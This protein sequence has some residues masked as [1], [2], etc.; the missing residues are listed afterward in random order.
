[1]KERQSINAVKLFLTK[2]L[3]QVLRLFFWAAAIALGAL[4]AW[5]YRHEVGGDG[6][7]YIDMGDAYLR[8]DWKMAINALWSPLYAW[9]LALGL[10]LIKPSTYWEYTVVHSINFFIFVIALLCFELFLRQLIRYYQERSVGEYLTIPVPVWMVM[11][12]TL[13][14][15]SSLD[16]IGLAWVAPDM[17][18][19]GLLYLSFWMLLR[20]R[21]GA[22]SYLNFALLGVFLGMG[23]L[24]KTIMLPLAFVFLIVATF[25]VSNLRRA[26]PR[27]LMSVV[28]LLLIVSPFVLALSRA[29][30]RITIGDS[31]KLNYVWHVNGIPDRHWQGQPFG[32]GVPL[33]PTRKL[34]EQ[35]AVFEF[36]SPIGGTYPM[37]YDPSYWYEGVTPRFHLK[38]Q[39][40]TLLSNAE[41]I[42]GMFLGLGGSLVVGFILL[43]SISRTSLIKEAV[44]YWFLLVPAVT[45]FVLYLLV[46]VE[47][48]YVAPFIVMICMIT[49]A[50]VRLPPARD[51][52]RLLAGLAVA[53]LV[54]LFNPIGPLASRRYYSSAIPL[55][56]GHEDKSNKYWRVAEALKALGIEPGDKVASTSYANYNN[57]TW[58]R[59]ARVHIIAE[60]YYRPG[61]TG[62]SDAKL[63]AE[64]NNFWAADAPVQEQVLCSVAHAGAKVIVADESPSWAQNSGWLNLGNTGY[65]AYLLSNTCQPP[66][67][68]SN[69]TN[70]KSDLANMRDFK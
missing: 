50:S 6:V 7:N 61:K 11:G 21:Q 66:F 48:R 42:T 17:C 4:Q 63:W 35:P 55:L 18:V 45:A 68:V 39:I 1:M 46:H 64:K 57:V 3:T 60:V 12:Y 51:S 70:L 37:W 34:L 67:S 40:K 15:W 59:L 58:A 29:K 26:C 54:M 47:S 2:H 33:H 10:H 69:Q 36:G 23:Y 32:S 20:I 25:S 27:V 16:L 13:F 28:V 24:A 49:F 52:T 31:G 53:M 30:G 5:A 8:G 19:A 14:L 22:T 44:H 9:L 38:Q 41:L 43:L 65:Y 62:N 56:T